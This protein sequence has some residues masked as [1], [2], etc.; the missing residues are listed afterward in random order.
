MCS[1]FKSI[2]NEDII[3]LTGEQGKDKYEFPHCFHDIQ[4]FKGSSLPVH[5]T[6]SLKLEE[7]DHP[8]KRL[9][10]AE[11][12]AAMMRVLGIFVVYA[13]ERTSQEAELKKFRA[14]L[15]IS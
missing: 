10:L 15:A 12:I 4:F 7:I 9:F 13:E 11:D 14:A 6:E 8:S 5:Q 2:R 3:E 1:R